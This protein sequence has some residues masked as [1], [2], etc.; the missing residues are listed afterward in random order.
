MSLVLPASLAAQGAF[1]VPSGD[2][3]ITAELTCPVDHVR[4]EVREG[5]LIRVQFTGGLSYA[6][7]PHLPGRDQKTVEVVLY[8]LATRPDGAERIREI[9]RCEVAQGLVG[10]AETNP[11]IEI[12]LEGLRVRSFE[13]K[14][15]EDPQEMGANELRNLFGASGSCCM[16][17]N[18]VTICACSVQTSCG[19]C[20]SDSCCGGHERSPFEPVQ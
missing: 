8:Q 1:G 2:R 15:P 6:L 12:Q 11:P 7:Q 13:T 3:I 18:G 16:H 9:Q 20:C 19:S 14:A 5:T 10:R 17:C 4:V